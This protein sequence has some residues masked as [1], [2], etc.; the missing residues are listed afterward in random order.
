MAEPVATSFSQRFY[1]KLEPIK[2]SDPALNWPLKTFIIALGTMFQEIEDLVDEGPNGEVGWSSI[3]D[4]DRIS[5]KGLAWIAQLIGVQPIIGMSAVDTRARIASTDGWSRGTREALYGAAQNLLTGTKEMIFVERDGG[6]YQLTV[7]TRPSETPSS[8]AVLAA[9]LAQKPA[10]IKLNYVV[11]A[12]IT[13]LELRATRASYTAV[14][15]NY[16]TY[17]ALRGF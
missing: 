14:L 5:D 1:D 7:I 12:G 11:S 8:A 16:A 17:T 4:I 9:L 6:P 13:Y 2:D 10:G 15:S 3:V